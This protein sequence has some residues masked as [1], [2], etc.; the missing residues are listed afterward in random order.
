MTHIW[1]T[2]IYLLL[3]QNKHSLTVPANNNFM[4]HIRV[5]NFHDPYM[6]H[7]FFFNSLSQS[8]WFRLDSIL[9]RGCA[10]PHVQQP[11]IPELVGHEVSVH[12]QLP[13]VQ[14]SQAVV[15]GGHVDGVHEGHAWYCLLH[16]EDLG[17]AGGFE[18]AG[19][20]GLAVSWAWK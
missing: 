15:Q 4:T 20:V 16:F 9:G 12:G 11:A 1:D 8:H 18:H 6:G 2:L 5:T 7:I 13:L 10:D 19:G 17:Q 3:Q 14:V